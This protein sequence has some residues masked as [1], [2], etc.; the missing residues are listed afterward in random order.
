MWAAPETPMVGGLRD[1]LAVHHRGP[2]RPVFRAVLNEPVLG[3][4]SEV[5]WF[6]SI[7]NSKGSGKVL[8]KL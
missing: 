7:C 8:K 1:R 6:V 2:G 4:W 3:L 5:V